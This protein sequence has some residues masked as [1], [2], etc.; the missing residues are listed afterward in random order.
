ML[1]FRRGRLVQL[2]SGKRAQLQSE[3]S[4][5]F[6]GVKLQTHC[7]S[8]G[9]SFVAIRRRM[10]KKVATCKAKKNDDQ[11]SMHSPDA[12]D[13]VPKIPAQYEVLQDRAP[14]IPSK[15]FIDKHQEQQISTIVQQR[16][17]NNWKHTR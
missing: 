2:Q 10:W 5:Y 8:S 9:P 12:P 4:I 7:F 15:T 3:I 17:E 1:C 16:R 6:V 11:Q 14:T 13:I